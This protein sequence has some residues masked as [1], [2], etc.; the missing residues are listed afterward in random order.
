MNT[1]GGTFEVCFMPWVYSLMHTVDIH[2]MT[3]TV[4]SKHAKCIEGL[5][6]TRLTDRMNKNEKGVDFTERSFLDKAGKPNTIFN[7]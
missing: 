3:R 2:V 4:A 1:C 7:K 5:R 6:V